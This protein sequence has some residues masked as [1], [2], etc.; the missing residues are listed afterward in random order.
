MRRSLRTCARELPEAFLFS[1]VV[2]LV[3]VIGFLVVVLLTTHRE[4]QMFLAFAFVCTVALA[5]I[6]TIRA[7]R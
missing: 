5:L 2:L 3:A 4:V 6:R 7:L 1:C